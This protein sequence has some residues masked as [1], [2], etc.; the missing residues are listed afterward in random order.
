MD[1]PLA[2]LLRFGAA[3]GGLLLALEGGAR[4]AGPLL[5]AS[6][7][8]GLAKLALL[9]RQ[10]PGV[11]VVLAGSSRTQ[12]GISPRLLAAEVAAQGGP[13]LRAFN[14]AFTSSTL[15]TL[16][17]EARLL[18]GRPGLRLVV[19]ELSGP[20]LAEGGVAW[21]EQPI[22]EG[23]SLEERLGQGVR[24]RVAL[25]RERAA[26][27]PEDLL[28]FLVLLAPAGRL[29]GSEV[30]ASEQLAAA[31]GHW[32]G[33]DGSAAGWEPPL[34]EPAPA[35]GP[36]GAP[37]AA[38]TASGALAPGHPLLPA[39]QRLRSLALALRAS[40]VQV[41]FAVPPL[42]PEAR[43]YGHDAEARHPF[44]ELAG[45]LAREFPVFDGTRLVPQDRARFHDTTHLN[46]AGRA[47]W[48]RGLG[49]ALVRAGLLAGPQGRR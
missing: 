10:G 6:T 5:H 14:L 43:G 25:V 22:G 9:D 42:S 7:N 37:T 49:R 24:A 39:L 23:G 47:G 15:A 16:E 19:L 48:S 11:A 46:A 45:A 1:N 12:D 34:L 20:Q 41:A 21:A 35:A 38:P 31:L 3:L 27:I 29:D 8:R 32:R 18:A 26:L 30:H 28:R 4:A 2:S 17:A 44:Q 40:G 33:D 36:P 13:P